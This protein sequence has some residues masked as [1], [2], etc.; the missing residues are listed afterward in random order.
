MARLLHGVVLFLLVGL[1]ASAVW[2]EMI[3]RTTDGKVFKIPV[4]PAEVKS[5]EFSVV[6]SAQGSLAD[7][8]GVWQTQEGELILTQRGASVVGRYVK[9]NGEIQGTVSGN[10]LTGY[11]IEDASNQ[12]CPSLKNGR[13]HWGRIR[14]VHQGNS[15]TG[16]WEYC[17]KDPAQSKHAWNGNR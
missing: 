7:F 11:W 16:K 15:F 12:R 17:A 4:A 1:V 3:V 8:A 6:K 10:V 14:F 5:I 13:A 9:D 2:A